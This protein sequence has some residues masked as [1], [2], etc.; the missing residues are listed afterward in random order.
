M[1]AIALSTRVPIAVVNGDMSVLLLGSKGKRVRIRTM[2]F[3]TRSEELSTAKEGQA[4]HCS[5]AL[6]VVTRQ[7]AE[8]ACVSARQDRQ[9]KKKDV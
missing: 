5:S 9:K 2:S 6:I 7:R 4:K 3:K 8:R 1:K